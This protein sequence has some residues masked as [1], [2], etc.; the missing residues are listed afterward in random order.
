[1][2][3][4]GVVKGVPQGKINL[5]RRQ[6]ANL[7]A[8]KMPLYGNARNGNRQTV[9]QPLNNERNQNLQSAV[10]RRQQKQQVMKATNSRH[11][12]LHIDENTTIILD[13]QQRTKT[14]VMSAS[15]P[16]PQKA[17]RGRQSNGRN[18]NGYICR[19]Y[20]KIDTKRSLP[21]PRDAVPVRRISS[22]L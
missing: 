8:I 21:I 18:Q 2:N 7:E 5:Q 3:P 4:T 16:Q 19:M 6:R 15:S 10:T 20:L 9:K 1:M 13:R 12:K 22:F 14:I 17:R 11:S